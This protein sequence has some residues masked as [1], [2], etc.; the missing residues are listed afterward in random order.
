L[1]ICSPTGIL[2]FKTIFSL[3]TNFSFKFQTNS[4][5]EPGSRSATDKVKMV[6]RENSK[7]ISALGIVHKEQ[8]AHG[9]APSWQAEEV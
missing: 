6:C 8:G 3:R 2:T 9:F 5:P 7:E 4:I 1:G